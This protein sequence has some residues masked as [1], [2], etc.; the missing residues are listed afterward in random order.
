M[1]LVSPSAPHSQAG[2]TPKITLRDSGTAQGPGKQSHSYQGEHSKSLEVISQEQRT[3]ARPPFERG[4]VLPY[5][6]LYHLLFLPFLS[7][8][9]LAVVKLTNPKR[10]TSLDFLLIQPGGHHEEESTGHFQCQEDPTPA[11]PLSSVPTE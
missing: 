9:N 1:W 5:T 4:E 6:P 3:K 8:C 2:P 7:R 11:T 10:K